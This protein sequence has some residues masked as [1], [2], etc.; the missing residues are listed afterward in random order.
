[1]PNVLRLKDK[2]TRRQLRHPGEL[3]VSSFLYLN[4]HIKT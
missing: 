2:G 4:A 1:M 3:T